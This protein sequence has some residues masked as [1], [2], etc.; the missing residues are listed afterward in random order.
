MGEITLKYKGIAPTVAIPTDIVELVRFSAMPNLNES[1]QMQVVQAYKAGAYEMAAEYVWRRTISRL[2]ET[3][4]NLGV[5]FIASMMQRSDID[6]Q[7]SLNSVL[8]DYNVICIAGQ[9]GI[10]NHLATMELKQSYEQIQYY[11]SSQANEEGSNMSNIK[12]MDIIQGCVKYV[13]CVPTLSIDVEFQLLIDRLL[14][15]KITEKDYLISNMEKPGSLFLARTVTTILS[16]TIKNGKGGE[17]DNALSNFKI[18]LPHIWSVLRKE[19]KWNI[20]ALYRDVVASGK[21]SSSR[22]VKVALAKVQGFDFVPESLR[23]DTFKNAALQLR[24]IHFDYD[25]F[26]CEEK[27]I[28]ELSSLGTIIPQPAMADCM[29]AYLLVYIGNFY[30]VSYGAA[31]IAEEQLSMIDEDEIKEYISNV[32]PYRQEILSELRNERPL[33]RLKDYLKEKGYSK[34]SIENPD[35]RAAY[36][37]ILKEDT[38]AIKDIWKNNQ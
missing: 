30:G 37:A 17:L 22:A 20:G 13:L 4:L 3:V 34:L 38:K 28:K 32:L 33:K 16:N 27:A 5:D 8:T 21:E 19:D 18:V 36:N 11:F 7:S 6:T 31:P 23:S 2:K 24:D 9:I 25:N 1:Q 14:T 12:C 26:Y 15:E 35:G 10:L 29:T